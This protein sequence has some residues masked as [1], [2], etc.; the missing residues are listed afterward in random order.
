METI[1]LLSTIVTSVAMPTWSERGFPRES[2][3][4]G[5]LSANRPRGVGRVRGV[6]DSRL[7]SQRLYC[8]SQ[9]IQLRILATEKRTHCHGNI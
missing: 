7:V 9:L 5:A 8:R 6:R 1:L 3:R 4:V 2:G